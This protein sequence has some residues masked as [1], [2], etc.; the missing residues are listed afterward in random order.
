MSERE[1]QTPSVYERWRGVDQI[2]Q[3]TLVA[4]GYFAMSRG[5]YFS[6][7]GNAQR[8]PGKTLLARLGQAIF[9]I[10]MLGGSVIIQGTDRVWMVPLAELQV[11]FVDPDLEYILD[12]TGAIVLDEAGNNISQ[13]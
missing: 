12:E 5:I 13:E 9:G 3:P 4:A 1:N 11:G 7:A 8:M 10:T 6:I 2:T